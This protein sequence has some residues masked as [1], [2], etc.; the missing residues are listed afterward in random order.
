MNII[1]QRR[2][3]DERKTS[4]RAWIRS[5]FIVRGLIAVR[6][7]P[8]TARVNLENTFIPL[9]PSYFHHFST[10][11]SY[12]CLAIRS[13]LAPTT[14]P[15]KLIDFNEA[16]NPAWF[17]LSP[18]ISPS[19]IIRFNI[20]SQRHGIKKRIKERKG[21]TLSEVR[22]NGAWT[23]N[24]NSDVPWG[25]LLPDDGSCTASRPFYL[26]LSI[27]KYVHESIRRSFP[28]SL[29]VFRFNDVK[30]WFSW[31]PVPISL[32]PFHSAC[33]YAL[34]PLA[35]LPADTLIGRPINYQPESRANGGE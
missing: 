11:P 23:R 6:G 29:S 14:F 26:Q 27:I 17:V 15:S 34:F 25:Q 21:T 9:I 19:L 3:R 18:P 20:I 30:W 13:P 5:T 31:N 16:Y 35:F 32:S 4:A 2:R 33:S 8:I 1:S 7:R 22:F 24:L 12:H 28:P 10:R